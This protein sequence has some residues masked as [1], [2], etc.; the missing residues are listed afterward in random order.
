MKQL[1]HD[2]KTGSVSLNEVPCPKVQAR[3]ILIK[4]HYSLISPGTERMLV[5][6]G[7]SNLLNKIRKQPDKVRMVLDKIKSDGLISTFGAV[8]SKMDE[9]MPMG[10]CNIGEVI[11]VGEKVDNYRIGDLVVSNGHHAEIIN[12]PPHLCAK[13]TP[14]VN[15]EAAAFTPL[16]SIALNS[17]RL[18]EPTLGETFLVSGL[19]IIGLLTV[20]L[21][22]LSGCN[23]IAVDY[24]QSRLELARRFG[25]QC[26]ALNEPEPLKRI[27][28]LTDY[29]GVDGVI[30]AA[31]TDS[32]DPV[33][34]ASK[35]CRKRGRI[36]LVGIT[37]LKLSR[38][39]FYAKELKFQ[40]ACSYGPGRYEHNY[41]I[42]G[43]DYPRAYVRW[44]LERN[45]KAIIKLLE[46]KQL[47]LA[48]LISHRFPFD[49]AEQAYSLLS[50]KNSSLGVL[51]EYPHHQLDTGLDLIELQHKSKGFRINRKP[52]I[53]CIGAGNYAKRILL[54]ALE[55]NK[56]NLI[57]IA[58]LNGINA[59]KA[60]KKFSINES[61]CS[62]DKFFND[63]NVDGIVVTTPH[64]D[65]AD[66]LC[67]A[68]QADKHIYLEKPLAINQQQL[69]S[70]IEQKNLAENSKSVIMLGFN[71]RFAPM[72]QEM[73]K[74]LVKESLPKSLI[75]TINAGFVSLDHW[76][77]DP[78][79]GGGR[80]IGETCHFI[81]L[82][83]YLV[84][85]PITN[86]QISK[87]GN[88]SNTFTINLEFADGSIGSI[89]YFANGH[90][91]LSKERLEIFCDNKVL[92][93][94][95]YRK[96]KSIGWHKLPRFKSFKQDKGHNACVKAFLHAMEY[97]TPSPIP[98]DEMI[99]VTQASIDLAKAIE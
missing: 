48:P 74:L 49:D 69:D 68:I 53:A 3:K 16:A 44:T 58:S 95:N 30:I 38:S 94:D 40:V 26:I 25:A 87:L 65:H 35:A 89:H 14:N 91:R 70:I 86:K 15:P 11:A 83:R 84:G 88:D 36:I 4:T 37:G 31:S 12:S 82:L 73:K 8:K 59:T 63:A 28:A 45:F 50:Q 81:D 17:I 21:L 54:P 60:A 66:W 93:L 42:K 18:A 23:V 57:S 34:L 98:F 39:E 10:Y 55:K 61:T 29:V 6:F 47:D 71:R 64:S 56:A 77:C 80:L 62:P 20:Q 97:N 13:I 24:D 1:L 19:G 78:E 75:M 41:E 72:V 22:K 27:Y 46:N 79:V 99:E 2:L 76:Q 5:E 7:K 85:Y 33:E 9:P 32:N 96:L 43:H 67:K 52:K 90:R 51:L 92:Q